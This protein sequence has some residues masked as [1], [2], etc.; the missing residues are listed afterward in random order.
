[1]TLQS[2][3]GIIEIPQVWES[4]TANC[5]SYVTTLDADGEKA[6]AVFRA[7]KSGD[8]VAIGFRVS[9]VTAWDDLKAGIETVDT[10]TG[11]P[12]GTAKG[13]CV[14]G[15][16]ADSDADEWKWVTLSTAAT[17]T[18]GDVI[19]AVIEF[20]SFVDGDL[21]IAN[22]VNGITFATGQHF[23]YGV[24]Y[25]GGAW[26]VT[27]RP[28]PNI[29]IKYSGEDACPIIGVDLVNLD[30]A[31]EIFNNTD[32]P[33]KIG[34]RISLSAPCRVKG[35]WGGLEVDAN[36][37]IV[38]YDSDGYSPLGTISLDSDIRYNTSNGAFWETFS[39]PIT[40]AKDTVYYIIVEPQEASDI[41]L[42]YIG[43]G[44]AADLSA[45]PLGTNCYKTEIAG[46]VGAGNNFVSH[47]TESPTERCALGL[48]VDQIDDGAGGSGGGGRR[49]R[50]RNHGV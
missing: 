48:L 30:D 29:G 3:G 9:T 27:A 36:L 5:D 13:G 41:R 11:F 17:V 33:D 19:A 14:P 26:A 1:M 25:V 44:V 10:T 32:T 15:T 39:S 47:S 6:G 21:T 28:V 4:Y 20:D 2:L 31:K 38:L 24:A 23:P 8:I 12:T 37:N 35:I 7:P 16:T 45:W 40:L 34:N 46:A 22:C 50:I 49:S 18:M 43:V 42:G